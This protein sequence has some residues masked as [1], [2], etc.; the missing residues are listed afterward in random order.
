MVYQGV[1]GVEVSEV[2]VYG[3]YDAFGELELLLGLQDVQL[4]HLT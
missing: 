1:A 2:C 3:G 4:R